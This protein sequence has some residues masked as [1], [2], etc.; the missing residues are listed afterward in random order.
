MLAVHSSS[1]KLPARAQASFTAAV[2]AGHLP[3]L[4]VS[5]ISDFADVA[6]AIS[7]I[8]ENIEASMFA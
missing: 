1:V 5:S 4:Q 2:L 7:E 8:R 3:A 6:E